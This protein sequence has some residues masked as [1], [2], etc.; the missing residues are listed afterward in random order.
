M[1]YGWVNLNTASRPSQVKTPGAVARVRQDSEAFVTYDRDSNRGRFGALRGGM[2]L[3]S[4]GGLTREVGELQQVVQTGDLL[5]RAQKLPAPPEPLEPADNRELDLDRAPSL[6]LSWNPV[7]GSARY[8]LQVSRNHLFVDTLISVE[9]RARPK[10]TLGLRG[11]GIFFW[12][13][14]AFSH[15]GFEG[16][17]SRPRRFRVA[18]FKS[19][20]DRPSAPPELDLVDVKSYGGIFIVAGHCTPGV[21]LEINGEQTGVGADGS[22]K[23]TVQ[24][25]K[26]GWSYIEIRARDRWG[27]ET[28]RRRRVLVESP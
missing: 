8:A 25:G 16:P 7:A 17:W 27:S 23:K 6:V 20:G 5:S 15:E 10:A 28:V 26:E 18:S 3:A 12:R 21:R 9:N 24:F 13:V 19:G 22:F 4:K 14:A 2:E 11:E 1:E